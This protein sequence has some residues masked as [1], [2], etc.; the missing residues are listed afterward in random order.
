MKGYAPGWVIRCTKSSCPSL[1]CVFMSGYAADI[2]ARHG[3]L[4]EGEHFIQKPFSLKE[5]MAK[6]QEVLGDCSA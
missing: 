4:D 6:L 3:V 1:R 5:I 2:I